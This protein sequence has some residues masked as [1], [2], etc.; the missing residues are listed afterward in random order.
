MLPPPTHVELSSLKSRVQSARDEARGRFRAGAGGAAVSEFYSQNVDALLME[1][2]DL[3]LAGLSES[4][5]EAVAASGAIVAVG[6]TGRGDLAPHSDV[7]LLFLDGGRSSAFRDVVPRLTQLIWDA[8]LELG[9]SLRTLGDCLALARSDGQVATALVEARYLWGERSLYG[10]LRK[11]F[12]ARIVKPRVRAFVEQCVLARGADWEG[13]HPTA[14]KLEPDVKKSLG[15]LR[16]LHLIRWLTFAA[17]GSPELETLRLNGG[18]PAHDVRSLKDAYEYLTHIRCD[19]HFHAGKAQDVLT[20]DEQLRLAAARGFPG[21]DVQRPV[22]QFMQEYFRHSSAIADIARRFVALQRRPSFGRRLADALA[23]HRFDGILLKRPYEIDVSPRHLPRVTCSLVAMLRLFKAA[24]LYGVL[25]APRVLQAIKDAV[26]HATFGPLSAEEARLFRDI[27]SSTKMV[28][29]TLRA[30]YECRLLDVVLPEFTHTRCL[31]QFNQYHHYTVDEHTLRAMEVVSGFAEDT[32]PAGAAYRQVHQKD[33][34]HL[35][36]LLHD[37]GKGYPRDHSDVGREIAAVVAER[38]HFTAEQQQQLMLLVHKHLVMPDLAIRRDITDERL[39]VSFAREVG[40]PDTLRMLYVLTVADVSAVGPGVL[41]SWKADLLTELLDRSMLIVSGRRYSALEERRLHQVR[42]HVLATTKPLEGLHDSESWIRWV[43][44]RLG[45]FSSYYLTTT[46]PERIAADLDA[47]Q[48]LGP[49]EIRVHGTYDPATGTIEYRII[50]WDAPVT[51]CFHRMA[52]VLTA[53]H[54]E[55]LSADINTTAGG[56]VIDSFRVVDGNFSGKVPPDRI[57]EVSDALRTVLSTDVPIESLFQRHRRF[58]ADSGRGPVAN[59]PLRVLVDHDTD[60]TRTI[61]DVYA[62]DRLGLLYTIARTLHELKLSVELAK[63]GTHFDQVVDVF[64]V[65]E[66]DGTKPTDPARL[67]EVRQSLVS[68][69]E[70][71]E[72]EG[73]RSFATGS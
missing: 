29:A 62:Y 57:D 48:R 31:L 7:D 33:L 24:T 17:W 3:S 18:L 16:D 28:G 65:T 67:Q 13:V 68:R 32:G 54:M 59:L 8:G 37:I 5:R 41:S 63:I 30:L 11:A 47:V 39:L 49:D 21:S 35:A 58:G 61:I 25:P 14:L 52:G 27:L 38:L 23:T 19:L 20:R 4:G 51:G 45:E 70:E 43:D 40:T 46:P 44:S 55:I 9:H 50:M 69:L 2:V 22:E 73:F 36:I 34:L 42:Q 26:A 6:G 1:F 72:R 12:R 71:F 56:V 64:Y 66:L 53:R 60:S 10:R 15:G